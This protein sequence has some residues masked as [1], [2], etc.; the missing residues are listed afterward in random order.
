M[1]FEDSQ[2]MNYL[3][4]MVVPMRREFGEVLNVQNFLHDQVYAKDVLKKALS[5]QDSGLRERAE[6][7]SKLRFGPR[8][9]DPPAAGTAKKPPSAPAAASGGRPENVERRKKPRDT[10]EQK[11]QTSATS[12]PDKALSAEEEMRQSIMKK[13]TS[14]LR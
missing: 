6:Y 4:R 7:I 10:P 14:G 8:V 3:V 13:Y 9:G 11:A 5:S 1:P 12:A 2:I